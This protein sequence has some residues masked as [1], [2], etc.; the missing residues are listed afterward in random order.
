MTWKDDL[1]HDADSAFLE[2]FD[3]RMGWKNAYYEFLSPE[4]HDAIQAGL[5]AFWEMVDP[6]ADQFL[7][8]GLSSITFDTNPFSGG[9]MI[10]NIRSTPYHASYWWGGAGR[11]EWWFVLALG[12]YGD[13]SWFD[14][15][16]R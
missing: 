2:A 9:A 15:R 16:A 5:Q 12:A 7:T 3:K 6:E 8:K 10:V 4:V 11:T 13:I 1:R 14:P